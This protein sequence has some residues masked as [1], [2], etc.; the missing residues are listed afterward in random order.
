MYLFD[1]KEDTRHTGLLSC[2][3]SLTYSMH[4]NSVTDAMFLEF[5]L[6]RRQKSDLL[7]VIIFHRFLEIAKN[8]NL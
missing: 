4:I 2:L 6:K 3:S 5:D 7:F 1:Y 8:T